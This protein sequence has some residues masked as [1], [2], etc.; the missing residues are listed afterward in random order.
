MHSVLLLS[1]GA[2]DYQQFTKNIENNV[3]SRPYEVIVFRL[4]VAILL[5]PSSGFI[6]LSC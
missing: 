2:F 1:H 6:R 5:K 4:T 3:H